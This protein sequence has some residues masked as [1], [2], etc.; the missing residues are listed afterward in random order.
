MKIFLR[1]KIL[2][3][4]VKLNQK[5]IFINKFLKNKK[6][7]KIKKIKTLLNLKILKTLKSYLVNNCINPKN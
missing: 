7:K 6:I 1:I 2:K 4:I 3:I 5:K